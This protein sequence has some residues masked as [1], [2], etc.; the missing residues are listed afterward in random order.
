[1][2]IVPYKDTFLVDGIQLTSAV[3]RKREAEQQ[4]VEVPDVPEIWLYGA[5][6]GDLPRELLK[7]PVLERMNV[8]VM[9]EQIAALATDRAWMDDPRVVLRKA[10]D[11]KNVYIP[12]GTSPV[13]VVKADERAWHLRDRILIV[14]NEPYN[15]FLRLVLGKQTWAYQEEG[16]KPFL[17]TDPSVKELFGTDDRAAIVIGGGPTLSDSYEWIRVRRSS[18]QVIAASTVLRVLIDQGITPD[19][20]IALDCDPSMVK[21]F[22][23]IDAGSIKLIY[24]PAV[25]TPILEG[26][27]GERFVVRPGELYQGGSVIHHELD[28]AVQRGSK[29]V[30]LLGADFCYPEM[31][32][33]VEGAPAPLNMNIHGTMWTVT[34]TG[35]KAKTD[36][37]LA[38]YRCLTEEYVLEHSEVK[39]LK[40]GR[41]GAETRGFQWDDSAA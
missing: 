35:E 2:E 36:P 15:E 23:G 1:M 40:R 18:M 10:E 20:V 41:A 30:Y 29:T 38:Q 11:C 16:N 39:W 9:S 13:E 37:S 6:L 17:A 26:W 14:R 7:R 27:H 32:S 3:D 31:R 21:H 28:L 34:G 19:V 4:A 33:H 22:S 12:F 24:P 8:V 25:A 5:S